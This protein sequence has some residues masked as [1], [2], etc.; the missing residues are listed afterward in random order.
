MGGHK[1]KELIV[2]ER[3]YISH[4]KAREAASGRQKSRKKLV[5]ILVK[6]PNFLSTTGKFLSFNI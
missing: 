6:I 2:G 4:E 1:K 3:G 5:P